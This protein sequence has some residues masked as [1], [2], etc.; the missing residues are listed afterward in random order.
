MAD[1]SPTLLLDQVVQLQSE[2]SLTAHEHRSPEFGLVD[3]IMGETEGTFGKRL[4]P[5]TTLAAVK[6]SERHSAFI[7]LFKDHAKT[8]NTVRSCVI[9]GDGPD[10][11]TYVLTYVTRGFTVTVEKH[12]FDDN[13]LTHEE[14]VRRQL[15]VGFEEIY[16]FIEAQTLALIETNKRTSYISPFWTFAGNAVQI[17]QADK[18][19]FYRRVQAIMRRHE[20]NAGGRYHI[21]EQFEAVPDRM[22]IG[23]QGANNGTNTGYQVNTDRFRFTET[24]AIPLGVTGVD[25]TRYAFPPGTLAMVNWVDPDARARNRVHEGKY[26][27][28]IVDPKYGMQFGVYSVKDCADISVAHPGLQRTLS[29][30]WEISADF[31]FLAPYAGTAG[32]TPILKF[33]TTLT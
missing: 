16:K 14:Y 31:A 24:N 23:Q 28:T 26:W 33:E 3:L 10:T 19:Q 1:I 17:P 6:A 9:T 21:V 8:L 12:A 4:V 2:N 32:E 27:E 7:P 25:Q 15:E 13:Y 30:G 18:D 29:Q 22:F 11:D 5:A 20:I